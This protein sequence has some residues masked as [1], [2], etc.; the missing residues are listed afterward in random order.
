MNPIYELL[1]NLVESMQGEASEGS[2]HKVTTI[3]LPFDVVVVVTISGAAQN[4]WTMQFK[5]AAEKP[6]DD[7]ISG[8]LKTDGYQSKYVNS[9]PKLKLVLNKLYDEFTEEQ[10][11]LAQFWARDNPEPGAAPIV[12][13]LQSAGLPPPGPSSERQKSGSSFWGGISHPSTRRSDGLSDD[14]E[15]ADPSYAGYSRFLPRD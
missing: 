6:L 12:R 1:K 13:R 9:M 8:I 4:S 7:K 5:D 10:K 14:D 3:M 11:K 2:V 15:D